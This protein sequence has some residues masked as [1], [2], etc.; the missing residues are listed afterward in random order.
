VAAVMSGAK[1][2]T[3]GLLDPETP[4]PRAGDRFVVEDEN[5]RAVAIVEL[6]EVRV[7]PAGEVDIQFARDEGEGFESVDQWRVAHEEFFDQA[8]DDDTPIVA[9]RF[10]VVERL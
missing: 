1:T 7:I 9:Q 5:D 3:A 6:T 8:L 2:T 10:R 4:P